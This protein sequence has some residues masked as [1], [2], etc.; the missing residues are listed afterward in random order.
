MIL[1]G[2]TSRLCSHGSVP[3]SRSYPDT[4]NLKMYSDTQEPVI[5]PHFRLECGDHPLWQ[6]Y[7]RDITPERVKEIM[8]R[9][10]PP[11]SE[12]SKLTPEKTAGFVDVLP[13]SRD[14]IKSL[15]AKNQSVP[16]AAPASAGRRVLAR[17]PRCS[18][19]GLTP[20]PCV[21]EFPLYADSQNKKSA[22]KS[23]A[24]Q[25]AVGILRIPSA[26]SREDDEARSICQA[27][28]QAFGSR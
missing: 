3:K 21:C 4:L 5:R 25:A 24:M 15:N 14:P 12:S 1:D 8:F 9:S 13:K 27:S 22:R 6:E 10:L 20:M 19:P 23:R 7:H 28:P 17:T 2:L 11:Q 26:A 18:S 16:S